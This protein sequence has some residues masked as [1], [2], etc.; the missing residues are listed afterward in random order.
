MIRAGWER[1]GAAKWPHRPKYVHTASGCWFRHCGH[2][3]ANWPYAVNVPGETQYLLTGGIGKGVAFRTVRLAME[4][5]EAFVAGR[6]VDAKGSECQP[7][8]ATP[9]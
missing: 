4:A 5:V 3:T 6:A 8:T 9:G 2:P 1:V 7:S